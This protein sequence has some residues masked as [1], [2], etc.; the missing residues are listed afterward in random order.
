MVKNLL[1]PKMQKAITV[2]NCIKQGMSTSEIM[3]KFKVNKQYVSYWRNHEI[4]NT[5]YRKKNSL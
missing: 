4:K 3:K 5:H 1:S 2:K